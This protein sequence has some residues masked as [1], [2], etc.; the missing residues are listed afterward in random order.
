M[1]MDKI[2]KNNKYGTM[3]KCKILDILEKS[4]RDRW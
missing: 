4:K 3:E 1:N 2:R